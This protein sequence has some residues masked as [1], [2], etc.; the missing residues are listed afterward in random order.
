M[1]PS[2]GE[3]DFFFLYEEC[4]IFTRSV[5]PDISSEGG[6]NSSRRPEVDLQCRP[7]VK[8]VL[9]LAVETFGADLRCGRDL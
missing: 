4:L 2:G 7:S 5:A 1:L 6:V 9:D 3:D 8:E